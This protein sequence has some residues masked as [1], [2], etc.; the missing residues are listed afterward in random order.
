MGSRVQ[1]IKISIVCLHYENV[2]CNMCHANMYRRV[3][4]KSLRFMTQTCPIL[5]KVSCNKHHRV[6]HKILVDILLACLRILQLSTDK[7]L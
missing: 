1:L 2:F 6:N 4:T 5:H 3:N 7:N